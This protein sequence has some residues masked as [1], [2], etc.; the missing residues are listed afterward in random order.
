MNGAVL[1]ADV[2]ATSAAIT[3]TRSRKA[4]VAAIADL[5]ARADPRRSGADEL[6]TVT[7]YVGGA[8]RQRRTGLGWRGLTKLPA[9][10]PGPTLSVLEVHE[11]FERI[12]APAGAGSQ[13]ARAAA[14]ADLFGRATAEEQQWLRGVVTGEVRQGAL[15]SLVQEGLAAAAGVPLPE[16]RRAAML[17]GSTVAVAAAAFEGVAA[18]GAVGL[19]VG[20]PVLP[21]LASSAPDLAA[22]LARA[23][24]DEVAVDTKLD[25]IRIQVHRSGPDVVVAT[26]S[27]EDITA[28]LPEV[29]EV[30]RA[31]PAD[32]FVLDGEALALAEDGRPRPFQETAARTAMGAGVEVTPYFF[33][34][35]HLDGADLLDVSA[36]ERAAVLERLVPAEHR[37]PRVVTADLGVAEEFLAGALR[38]GHEGVVV[39]SLA[40]PYEAGRRGASWVK[41]KPV[42]TLDLVVL[43]VEWGS[44]RR[45]GWLSNIH[46]GARDPATGGLVML[47][48]TFKGMT[49]EV[50][51]W[52]TERFLEL[53]TSR[54]AHVV[55]VRPEQVVEI[56]FDGVQR[57]TRYPG[58]VALR[59][60]RVLR[61][62]DD[63]PVAEI[64]TV[65]TVRSFLG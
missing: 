49:D 47:G 3:A 45:Q 5:L 38:S 55:H 42:H 43:A 10:A 51:A 18:L 20:R 21:M 60:A 36:A 4:K 33:D 9:P 35:L 19:Q 26:R 48:K 56:A 52:Q 40:A 2:V 57:S 15:D 54:S 58:G 6:E 8:L 13:A 32:S 50:L 27:L 30:A 53:E 12:A 59:F 7:A 39:K 65:D 62:R 25:G 31:L 63:K 11:A 61:Y 16:V 14:V 24:G 29:V 44:G 64:D 46:L 17:A 23:G 1:I 37:V 22:A 34:V 41:V 28:R